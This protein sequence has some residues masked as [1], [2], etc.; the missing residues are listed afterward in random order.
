MLEVKIKAAGRRYVAPADLRAALGAER[1]RERLADAIEALLVQLDMIDGDPD[2]EADD[3]ED[4]FELSAS[5]QSIAIAYPPCDIE[6]DSGSWT[7]W[8]TRGRRKDDPGVSG[9]HGLLHED[10]ED[11]D[12]REE[13]DDSGQCTEDEISS[14]GRH[15]IP[16]GPGC[17]ISDPSELTSIEGVYHGG[18]RPPWYDDDDEPRLASVT[19]PAVR[20]AG[21]YRPHANSN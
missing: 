18:A 19:W 1:A 14:G 17:E 3:T 13:D 10:D 15:Y 9:R 8:H 20:D 12:P 4:S 2:L 21:F 16:R 6:Q 11:D 5:A 7:E